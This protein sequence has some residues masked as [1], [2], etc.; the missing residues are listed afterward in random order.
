MS[1]YSKLKIF[2]SQWATATKTSHRQY[3]EQ[4]LSKSVDRCDLER[5]ERELTRKGYM[6]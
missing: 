2:F 3:I 5:R 1:L 4:Y 6:R